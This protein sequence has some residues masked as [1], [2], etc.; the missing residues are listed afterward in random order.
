MSKVGKR[1][2]IN[3]RDSLGAD[4]QET[5]PL[6]KF[7]PFYIHYDARMKFLHGVFYHVLNPSVFDFG[8]E[9]D[10]STGNFHSFSTEHGPLDYYI[11]LCR[12]E[13]G[14]GA[15]VATAALPNLPGILS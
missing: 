7:T 2:F 15:G 3:A 5:D 10:F 4:S 8:A 9:Y 12:H 14:D 1:Y 13:S 6:Y 11:L